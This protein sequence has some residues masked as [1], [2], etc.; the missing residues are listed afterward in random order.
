[1]VLHDR[2]DTQRLLDELCAEQTTRDERQ[3]CEFQEAIASSIAPVVKVFEQ[4]ADLLEAHLASGSRTTPG[5][6]QCEL[7]LQSCL[8]LQAYMPHH[9]L[10]FIM[11][12]TS[13]YLLGIFWYLP[14]T[15]PLIHDKFHIIPL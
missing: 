1:M 10:G 7:Q 6:A 3:C 14:Y 13:L 8:L 5:A 9:L 2:N 4:V 11:P 12:S 15:L